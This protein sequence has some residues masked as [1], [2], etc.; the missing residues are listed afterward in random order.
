MDQLELKIKENNLENLE[1]LK[2]ISGKVAKQRKI[3]QKTY[4]IIRTRKLANA[5][6]QQ[7][8]TQKFQVKRKKKPCYSRDYV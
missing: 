2:I 4:K 8:T 5:T 3:K 1:I 7:I 6:I